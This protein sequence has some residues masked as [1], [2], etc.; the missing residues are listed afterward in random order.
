[1]FIFLRG[2][3]LFLR[4]CNLFTGDAAVQGNI[5]FI[6]NS[7]SKKCHILVTKVLFQNFKSPKPITLSQEL[8]L[9]QQ[10]I[11]TIIT[12]SSQFHVKLLIAGTQ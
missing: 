2:V 5:T 9:N 8:R 4:N 7:N 12:F 6:W 11:L 10:K 3:L 1:M